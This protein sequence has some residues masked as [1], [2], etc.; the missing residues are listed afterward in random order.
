MVAV[1]P[2]HP[3]PT[4]SSGRIKGRGYIRS[5]SMASHVSPRAGGP[6]W[7]TLGNLGSS[8]AGRLEA[9]SSAGEAAAVAKAADSSNKM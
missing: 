7:G 8:P 9:G 1:P 2:P 5:S 4:P 3:T 6:G